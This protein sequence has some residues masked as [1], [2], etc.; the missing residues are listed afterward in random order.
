MQLKKIDVETGSYEQEEIVVE[1]DA[2]EKTEDY[3]FDLRGRKQV[4]SAAF[5]SVSEV[6]EKLHLSRTTVYTYMREF[7]DLLADNL[8]RRKGS[9]ARD[10]TE[11]GLAMLEYIVS[12]RRDFKFTDTEIRE[13]IKSDAGAIAVLPTPGKQIQKLMEMQKNMIQAKFDELNGR[14][15][16]RED[17]IKEEVRKLFNDKAKEELQQKEAE[18][19]ALR[20]EVKKLSQDLEK[21]E[22]NI[23]DEEKD[24]IIAQ[25]ENELAIEKNKP[26]GLKALFHK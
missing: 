3:D 4:T 18:N 1:A 6:S 11:E 7:D 5:Y 24:R 17:I 10:F 2:V 22:K 25:L 20:N 23:K 15:E 12:L 26:R 8:V 9:S 14:I 19:E 16:L 21:L 13:N